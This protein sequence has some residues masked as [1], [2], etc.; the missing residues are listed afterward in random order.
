MDKVIEC[1]LIKVEEN[2]ISSLKEL[3]VCE[4]PLTIVLNKR[5]IATLLCTPENLKA[6]TI[7]FLKTERLIKKIEDITSFKLDKVTGIAEVEIERKDIYAED[8]HSKKVDLK[9]LE[10][11]NSGSF[12]DFLDAVN[13]E[14]VDSNI[15]LPIKKVYEF[16]KKNLTYSEVFKETGGVHCIALCDTENVLFMREDVARH[17]AL[18]KIIGEA[19]IKKIFLK[20]KI[21]ILSGRVSLEMVLKAAKMQIPIIVA[22]GAPTNL[23]V[24]LAKR[25]NI[26]LIAFVR[27]KKMNIYTN[28]Q[29]IKC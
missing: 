8:F 3:V 27:D 14:I 17:N 2:K 5:K 19:I 20:D 4:Y 22:K 10:G 23:A 25:L 29:R 28:E 16:V 26:T 15:V 18:D 13:C 21:I 9:N 11:F 6:L 7:G 24:D 12:G 1:K